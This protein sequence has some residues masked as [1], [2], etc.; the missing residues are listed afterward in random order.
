MIR[1]ILT[2]LSLIGLLLSVGLWG[3]SLKG[4]YFYYPY[5]SRD[6][7]TIWISNGHAGVYSAEDAYIKTVPFRYT[8]FSA[9]TIQ[10]VYSTGWA[11]HAEIFEEALNRL[12]RGYSP[13]REE[14]NQLLKG[15]WAGSENESRISQMQLSWMA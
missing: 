4:A 8:S 15:H 14:I 9:A 3:L 12:P 10:S 7:I 2:T 1:K 11:A 13:A 5:T 6:L